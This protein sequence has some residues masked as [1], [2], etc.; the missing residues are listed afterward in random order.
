MPD[1]IKWRLILKWFTEDEKTVVS[2]DST[3]LWMQQPAMRAMLILNGDLIF[4]DEDIERRPWDVTITRNS[5]YEA[6]A[7]VLN[8]LGKIFPEKIY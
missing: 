5:M 8:E 4:T 1:V 7:D 2:N 3:W 6:R